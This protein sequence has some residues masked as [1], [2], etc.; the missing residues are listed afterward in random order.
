MSLTNTFKV[1]SENEI[2]SIVEKAFEV[3]ENVGVKVYNEPLRKLLAEN[4]AILKDNVIMIPRKLIKQCLNS[5]PKSFSVYDRTGNEYVM[6][7]GRT[8]LTS[9]SDA[10]EILDSETMKIRSATREDLINL[11]KI[12]D[13]LDEITFAALQ[14]VPADD[15]GVIGQLNAMEI[16]L[17]NTNKP[18]FLEPLDP[19]IAQTWVEIEKLLREN[20][21][22]Y[23]SPSIVM[24]IITLSPLNFDDTNSQKLTL[25]AKNNIPILT[26]PCPFAG[27]TSPFTLAG[28]LVQSVAE[29]LF[30][31]TAA[32]LINEGCPIYF[33]AASTVMDIKTG[34]IT[35]GT[36]ETSLV[37]MAFAEIAAHFGLPSYTPMIHPDAEEIDCQM[38]M[39]MSMSFLTQ[40][41]SGPTIMPGAGALNKTSIGSFEKLVIDAEIFKI[42]KRIYQGIEVNEKYLA[43]KNIANCRNIDSYLTDDLT[44]NELR[45]GEH[46]IPE[47][48]NRETRGKGA[49]NMLAK[50]REKV[51]DILDN[52]KTD[53][54]EKLKDILKRFFD[55]KR[56]V[57]SE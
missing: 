10:I 20:V 15:E 44:V 39:E 54:D 2:E 33:G 31:L 8:Y 55:S 28:T 18:L 27:M 56:N 17:Q 7:Q 30:E 29:T 34:T 13:S 36:P 41:S 42:A 25:A 11:T 38:G 52:H 45:S 35:Y 49:P 3:N 12:A 46:Y 14:V 50:A 4:G 23:K 43:Y 19:Y 51:S 24:V 26:A 9:M 53:V 57:L 16:I 37:M 48:L 21:A 47:L 1:L 32:Q 6:E 5:A 22:D 40:L